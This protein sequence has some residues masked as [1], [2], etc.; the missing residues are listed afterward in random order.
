[1]SWPT[2]TR[3]SPSARPPTTAAT[4]TATCLTS[5]SAWWRGASATSRS[6]TRATLRWRR[7]CCGS[8]NGILQHL[9]DQRRDRG[10][11]RADQ[12][13]VREQRMALE[14]LD[15]RHH[16]VVPADPQVVALRDVV[17]EHDP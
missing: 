2:P 14:L 5:R 8:E 17:G 11:L 7:R 1:M 3:T 9:G 13:D 15:D 12:R 16:A 4:C 6:L 10:P